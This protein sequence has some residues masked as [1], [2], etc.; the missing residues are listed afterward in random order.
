LKHFQQAPNARLLAEHQLE[1]PFAVYVFPDQHIWK[2]DTVREIYRLLC[3]QKSE[4]GVFLRFACGD[5]LEAIEACMT[6]EQ[7]QKRYGRRSGDYLWRLDLEVG[8]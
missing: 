8:L 1:E 4:L 7:V 6:P 5:A 3:R 2:C